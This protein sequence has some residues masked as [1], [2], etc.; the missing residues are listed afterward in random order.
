MSSTRFEIYHY[1]GNEPDNISDEVTAYEPLFGDNL[2]ANVHYYPT[3]VV[4]VETGPTYDADY[5]SLPSNFERFHSPRDNWYEFFR[6]F[7]PQIVKFM[8]YGSSGNTFDLAQNNLNSNLRSEKYPIHS[9]KLDIDG[10]EVGYVDGVFFSDDMDLLD[11]IM[12]KFGEI[13][14]Y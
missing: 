11:K 3:N 14:G 8:V 10:T 4:C 12:V 7:E 1:D 13:V 6:L 5:H 2:T 9:V